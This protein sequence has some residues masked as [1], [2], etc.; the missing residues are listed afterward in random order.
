M[1]R[2][3]SLDVGSKRIGVAATDDLGM[4]VQGVTVIQRQG[5]AQATA[6]ICRLIQE[7]RSEAVVVGLPL[8]GDDGE[9]GFQAQKV[10]AFAAELEAAMVAQDCVVPIIEWDES[11][12]THDAEATLRA[13]G[14][15]RARRG[16]V[17]DQVAAIMI[18]ESYLR[19]LGGV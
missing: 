12:T 11:M 18:L 9:V 1:K 10:R 15:R 5:T 7:R 4:T 3:L 13:A 8:R 6:E 19:S 2:F 17:I 16:K 14:V